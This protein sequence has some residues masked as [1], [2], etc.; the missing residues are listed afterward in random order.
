MVTAW[1]AGSP[2]F[3]RLDEDLSSSEGGTGLG[4]LDIGPDFSQQHQFFD[5]P[6]P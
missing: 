6:G 5:Q 3:Q 2:A 4:V 1:P